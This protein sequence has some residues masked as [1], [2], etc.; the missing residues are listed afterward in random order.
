[1]F[2][3]VYFIPR[4]GL[5]KDITG[6]VFELETTKNSGQPTQFLGF[7]KDFDYL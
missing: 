2:C 1:M 5:S 7:G 4:H 3:F 6:S